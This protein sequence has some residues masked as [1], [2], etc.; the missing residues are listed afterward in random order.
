MIEHKRIDN[1][2]IR[3]MILDSLIIRLAINGKNI[4]AK[5]VT[6]I[7]RLI[8]NLQKHKTD[9]KNTCSLNTIQNT[10]IQNA[11]YM[12][13]L[14][15]MNYNMAQLSTKLCLD[16]VQISDRFINFVTRNKE[17]ANEMHIFLRSVLLS[18]GNSVLMDLWTDILKQL[19]ASAKENSN[20]A[21]ETIYFTLYLLAKETDGRKQMELLRGLTS[22][23]GVKENIP[24]ILNTYR[25]LSSS[26]SA[27]LQIIS[28]D[29]HT[30]LWL[31]ENRTYQFLHKLLIAEDDKFSVSDK[32]EM[33]VVK[34][35]AIKEICAQ[36]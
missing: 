29:L 16:V 4:P 21:G 30:R 2:I 23:S 5:V 36:K 20:L 3:N 1:M 14:I 8:K 13:P 18:I 28:I 7:E 31:A 34:A 6:D 22:F 10:S 19:L 24:L 33:N 15:A 9:S 32:W 25:S 12:H 11:K 26:T 35:Y 17:F 27:E